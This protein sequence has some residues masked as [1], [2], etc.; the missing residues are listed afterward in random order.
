MF[1]LTAK[2]KVECKR[3]KIKL[4]P[5]EVEALV[6][7]LIDNYIAVGENQNKYV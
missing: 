3:M 5:V 2:S 6:R 1:R 7:D 4:L